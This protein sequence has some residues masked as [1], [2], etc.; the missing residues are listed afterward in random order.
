MQK[1]IPMMIYAVYG[2]VLGFVI[3]YMARRFAKF[4]PATA[5]V[6]F[7]RLI[8]PVKKVARSK[9]YDREVYKKLVGAYFWRSFMY[10][11]AGGVLFYAASLH[12]SPLGLGGVLAFFWALLLLFE[13]DYKTMF[14]PDVV[15][16]PLL[17]GGFVFSS[18]YGVWVLP[19]ESAL[20]AAA[21]YLLPVTAAVLI[22]WKHKD[23]FGGGDIKLLAAVGAWLG[24]LPVVYTIL[25]A[26]VLF[27]VFAFVMRRRDGAFGPAISLAAIMLAFYFF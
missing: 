4:M 8:L 12:F 23:A 3:P 9:R 19:I 22:V 25:A 16:V 13:I 17:I 7:W 18:F 6:A 24:L 5:A 1:G 10:G 21:G 14:L 27:A 26:S 20:G 2:F 15:T 11:I